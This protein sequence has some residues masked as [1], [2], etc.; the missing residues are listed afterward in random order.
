VSF[1]RASLIT[2][3]HKSTGQVFIQ[4]FSVIESA[5]FHISR[6]LSWFYRSQLCILNRQKSL[7]VLRL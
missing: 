7:R 6:F 4:D 5:N 1:A 3:F 2:C